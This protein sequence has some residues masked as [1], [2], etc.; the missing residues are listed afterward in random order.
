MLDEN[1]QNESHWLNEFFLTLDTI[2][3]SQL[4]ILRLLVLI[5]TFESP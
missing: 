1:N 3:D 4:F 5:V 2:L